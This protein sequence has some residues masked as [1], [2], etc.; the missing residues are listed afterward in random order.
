MAQA[1]NCPK[2]GSQMNPGR[3]AGDLRIIK[4]GDLVGDRMTVFYCRRCGYVEF[5]KE[6]STKEPWRF[7]APIQEPQPQESQSKIESKQPAEEPSRKT[8]KRLVR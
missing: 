4:E 1:G 5:Y 7:S 8:E 3:M 2:C 6:A